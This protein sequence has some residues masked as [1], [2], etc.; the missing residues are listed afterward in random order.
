MQ[1]RR[2]SSL[3]N[4]KAVNFQ[5]SQRTANVSNQT[6]A[7]VDQLDLSA[8]AQLISQSNNTSD[9]RM[10]RVNDLREQIASGRYES[11]EKIDAAVERLLDQLF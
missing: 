4:A 8:E 2:T 5:S 7:P 9:I 1:I 10:D 6:S 11:R 3:Q